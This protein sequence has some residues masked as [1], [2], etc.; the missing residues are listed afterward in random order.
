[1]EENPTNKSFF[2]EIV[3]S[4][5]SVKFIN[6]GSQL[7]SRDY[8]SLKIWDVKMEN[9]PLAVIPI[10]DYLRLHLCDLYENDCI[11]DRFECSASSD[12][13]QLVTG[14]YNNNF[15]IHNMATNSSMVIEAGKNPSKSAKPQKSGFGAKKKSLPES[16]N[17]NLMDFSKRALHV[18][19]HPSLST[20]S[21]AGLNKLYIYSGSPVNNR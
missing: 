8:L 5:S 7:L 13:S 12:G 4:L 20:I 21:V 3:S 1:M 19:W 10:H 18:A 2:S 11:F 15:T 6:G 16:P 14:S 17:V 9:K